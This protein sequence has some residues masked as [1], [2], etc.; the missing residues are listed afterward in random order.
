MHLV[1]MLVWKFETNEFFTLCKEN[2]C[3]RSGIYMFVWNVENSNNTQPNWIQ[4]HSVRER[5]SFQYCS[6]SNITVLSIYSVILI[7]CNC[8]QI[9]P[10]LNR[11]SK[12][13][14]VLSSLQKFSG[15][16]MC[17][18][19]HDKMVFGVHKRWS[20]LKGKSGCLQQSLALCRYFYFFFFS[21]RGKNIRLWGDSQKQPKSIS[22]LWYFQRDSLQNYS[23]IG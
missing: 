9:P 21:N 8:M 13:N 14:F 10:K 17:I 1:W 11:F 7:Y 22:Q 3:S 18:K 6:N 16:L 20:S 15:A 12:S 19:L 23:L 2:R 4:R 5:L